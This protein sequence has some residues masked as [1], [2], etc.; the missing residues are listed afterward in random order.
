MRL[1]KYI[2][3][4]GIS[5]RRKAD[6]LI[7]AGKVLVNGVTAE[8]GYQ[9]QE[10]D[11]IEINSKLYSFSSKLNQKIYIALYKPKSYITSFE[12]GSLNLNNLLVEKNFVGKKDDFDLI[13]GVQLHYAGRLDKDSS[14]IILLT[15]DGD[16]SYHLTHPKYAS[17]KEYL[18]RVR[19]ILDDQM[20]KKLSQGVKIEPEQNGESV[21]T[22]PCFVEQI[23]S[24]QYRII[25]NQG[26][27]RQIRLM[28]KGVKNLVLELKRIRIANI[29]LKEYKIFYKQSL[30]KTYTNMIFLDQLS[31]S[32]YCLIEK[33]DINPYGKQ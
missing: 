25:L 16:F 12:K 30:K 20:I 19:N 3:E 8:T 7:K 18:V 14:G 29:A 28:T 22:N 21:I 13:Q 6:D 10:G 33:P 27:K 11:Q 5:S 9:L 31:E 17:E 4:L 23:N 24:H 26:F 32:Q 1:N 15:N 2:V